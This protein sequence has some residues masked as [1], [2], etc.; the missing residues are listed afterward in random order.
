MKTNTAKRTEYFK[1]DQG[2]NVMGEM[3]HLKEVGSKAFGEV[4]AISE[5]V[6]NELK[7]EAARY[8]S[9]AV[10]VI[11]KNP[12][13]AIAAV[14]TVGLVIARAMRKP[15]TSGSEKLSH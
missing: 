4:E 11:R 3:K 8:A 13:L 9:E 6:F 1:G 7:S 14:V 2:S 10:S 5:D 15:T 12:L